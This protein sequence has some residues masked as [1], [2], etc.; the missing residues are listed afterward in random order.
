MTDADAPI[1]PFWFIPAHGDGR[2]LGSAEGAR[3]TE[4]S[5]LTQVAETADRLGFEGVLI[6][7][8]KTC[9]DS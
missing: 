6:P 9:E 5:Y 7:T 2:W 8:G 4:I 1:R 3:T